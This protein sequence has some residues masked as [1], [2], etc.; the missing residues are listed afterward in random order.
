M[1]DGKLSET[2]NMIATLH[3]AVTMLWVE[4]FLKRDDPIE[5]AKAYAASIGDLSKAEYRPPTVLSEEA[6]ADTLASLT[7][8]FENV[9]SQVLLQTKHPDS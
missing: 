7:I 6:Q 1:A 9:V 4:E 8:F 3:F 5:A 2:D